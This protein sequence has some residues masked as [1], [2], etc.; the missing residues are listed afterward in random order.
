MRD[1]Y[2]FMHPELGVEWASVVEKLSDLE[3]QVNQDTQ[4][5]VVD[6]DLGVVYLRSRRLELVETS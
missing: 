2:S 1:S 4:I 5:R 3:P 6:W